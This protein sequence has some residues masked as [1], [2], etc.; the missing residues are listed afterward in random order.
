MYQDAIK[1]SLETEPKPDKPG[2]LAERTVK[3]PKLPAALQVMGRRDGA[4]RRGGAVAFDAIAPGS[5]HR[6]S[7]ADR[8]RQLMQEK[9]GAG[10]MFRDGSSLAS[11]GMGYEAA[12]RFLDGLRWDPGSRRL[13]RAFEEM[14]GH[15]KH[16]SRSLWGR[17]CPCPV[18]CAEMPS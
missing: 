1:T 18:R 17:P 10:A 12:R 8:H 11:M 13:N 15:G 14:M 2:R 3:L 5:P 7:G 9:R 4:G 16:S 6:A